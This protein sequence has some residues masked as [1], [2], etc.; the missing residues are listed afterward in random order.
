MPSQ[1]RRGSALVAAA[2]ALA[3]CLSLVL[4]FEVAQAKAYRVG[5]ANGWTYGNI[6]SWPR[7]RHFR[8]GDTLVFK[9]DAEQYDVVVVNRAQYHSC[10]APNNATTY[11]TG[12]DHIKLVKGHHFFMCN[13]FPWHCKA[14]MRIAVKVV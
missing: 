12:N 7:G 11:H 14:G 1:G 4:N 10:N 2:V 13:I 9:Y 6:A 3:V 5:G 8:A